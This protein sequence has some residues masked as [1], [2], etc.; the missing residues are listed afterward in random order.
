MM[1][2]ESLRAVLAQHHLDAMCVRNTANIAYLTDFEGV[3]DAEQA[4]ALLVTPTTAILHTDSRYD[5]ACRHAADPRYIHIDSATD[6]E[7]RGK[8]HACWL[9]EQVSSDSVGASIGIEDT[10]T[11]AEFRQLEDEFAQ[12]AG[13]MQLVETHDVVRKLRAVKHNDELQR[14]RAAQAITDSAFSYM[15]GVIKPGMTERQVQQ[16][17]DAFMM[18]HGADELAFPSIVATGPNAAN[19]HAQPADTPLEAGQCLVMDFGAKKAGYCSDMTRTIFIGGPDA[20]LVSA[21]EVL[22]EA[23]EQ[24]EA[25]LC[26]GITGLEAHNEA[27]RILEEGGFGG[28]MGHGLGHGLGRSVHE[29]PNLNLRNNE[30]LEAG[31]V[32]TVEPGIYVEGAW[33]MRLEDFGVITDEGFDV[34]TQSSHD[35]VII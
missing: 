35:L 6:S 16:E 18:S 15:L 9:A 5:N 28:L 7:G 3:F 14:L 8:T 34:F 2:L 4:H 30:A 29:L 24:V 31:N 22:R 19:P 17:L 13:S 11:L 25:M 33:G 23:N 1:R 21:Y 32:V 12:A 26:P 10:I 27:Q 20:Q